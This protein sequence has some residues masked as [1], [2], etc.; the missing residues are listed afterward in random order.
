MKDGT[1][2][3]CGS[4]EVYMTEDFDT[5]EARGDNLHFQAMQ[6]SDT[7]IFQFDTYV[8]TVCGFTAMFA[9]GDQ[10][11]YFLRAADNW[12]KAGA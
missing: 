7:G 9:K 3:M 10:D 8:C 2:P 12:R 11:L 1:C 4:N 6:G 5:L